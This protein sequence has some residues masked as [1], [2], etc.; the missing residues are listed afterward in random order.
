MKAALLKRLQRLEEVRAAE[1]RPVELQFGYLKKLP[2]D[3]TG[4]RHVV[5]LGR[6]ADG[7]YQWEERPGPAPV[8]EEDNSK[9]IIR[10]NLVEVKHHGAGPTP[11][12]RARR[13]LSTMKSTR[14]LSQ[15][16]GVDGLVNLWRQDLWG[17]SVIF[18]TPVIHP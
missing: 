10:M 16:L 18:Q 11:L 4:E 12:V 3:Y 17:R 7:N 6:L 9:T 5:T 8:E 13:G 1:P 14:H 15:P 2:P